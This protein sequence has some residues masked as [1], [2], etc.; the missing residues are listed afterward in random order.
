MYTAPALDIRSQIDNKACRLIL[1]DY[2]TP[3]K[4]S[5]RAN[6]ARLS[7]DALEEK[8]KKKG[9]ELDAIFLATK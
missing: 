8:I 2:F 6:G 4:R 7:P 9:F 5:Q 3:Q 1:E